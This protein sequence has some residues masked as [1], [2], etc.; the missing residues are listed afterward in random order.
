MLGSKCTKTKLIHTCVMVKRYALTFVHQKYR[1]FSSQGHWPWLWPLLASGLA[2]TG[3]KSISWRFSCQQPLP[4][5]WHQVHHTKPPVDGICSVTS[6]HTSYS[7]GIK[8][9]V[10]LS[11]GVLLPLNKMENISTP[12][13][14][15]APHCHNVASMPEQD[16]LPISEAGQAC[17]I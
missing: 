8:A 9:V 1:C 2:T 4:R 17:P 12:S 5:T 6:L 7:G 3:W 10:P 14:S 16:P 11:W 15:W 13:A